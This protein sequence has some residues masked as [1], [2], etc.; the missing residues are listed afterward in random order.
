MAA[1]SSREHARSGE[2][3]RCPLAARFRSAHEALVL[4]ERNIGRR[5]RAKG[6]VCTSSADEHHAVFARHQCSSAGRNPGWPMLKRFT[7]VGVRGPPALEWASMDSTRCQ[8]GGRRGS[9]H[10]LWGDGP[11]GVRRRATG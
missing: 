6:R 10:R 7:E 8:F 3:P 11:H 5:L 9:T 1:G 4:A 2:A